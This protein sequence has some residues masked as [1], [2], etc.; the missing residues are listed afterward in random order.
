MQ[1][2]PEIK[3]QLEEQKKQCLFCKI[4]RKEMPAQVVFEDDTTIAVLDIYPVVK[5]HTLFMPKEH[6]PLQAYLPKEEA[7]HFTGLV[8]ALGKAIREGIPSTALNI[9]IANGGVAGQ[10]SGHFLL[11]LLPRD[12]G[13]GFFHFLFE[14][15]GKTL[16]AEQQTILVQQFPA[17][18]Q[19]HFAN[20]PARWHTGAGAVP[21]HLK[22][23]Y[24]KTTIL[25]DDEKL[26][27]ALAPSRKAC[28]EIFSKNE[29]KYIGKL[30]AEDAAHCFS[31]A[32][33]AASLLFQSLKA[34]G[35]NIIVKS[36]HTD[37][38]PSGR[39]CW[40]VLARWQDDGLDVVWKPKRPSYELASVAG[41]I[42]DKT[43]QIQHRIPH[44]AQKKND[45]MPA[46]VRIRDTGLKHPDEEIARAI[47]LA[48]RR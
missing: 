16:T 27:V 13:D 40:Y 28:L 7:A 31:V 22:G 10:Q 35:T 32:S 42:K 18:M 1:L 41:K 37:D 38:N 19:Q 36:G 2:T 24:Q 4:I 15:K 6:Y 14:G 48:R 45:A 21:E 3:Q 47:E 12:P 33:S 44:P 30:P 43:W 17:L 8:P 46:A 25:Y 29:E 26:A 34:Q 5:G 20:T 39:L 23:I 11:H 9:F